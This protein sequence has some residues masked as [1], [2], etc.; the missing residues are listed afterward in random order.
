MSICKSE[1]TAIGKKAAS[2]KS[3]KM[4]KI[5]AKFLV[6]GWVIQQEMASGCR[7]GIILPQG[8]GMAF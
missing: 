2:E 8:F 7:I 5:E 6:P 4:N 1:K 3:E